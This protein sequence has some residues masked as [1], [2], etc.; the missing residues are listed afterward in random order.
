MPKTKTQKARA[1]RTESAER[2]G[3]APFDLEKFECELFNCGGVE[4]A[5]MWLVTRVDRKQ[6]LRAKRIVE[7]M[8]ISEQREIRRAIFNL[9][10]MLD[11]AADEWEGLYC[12]ASNAA[13]AARRRAAKKTERPAPPPA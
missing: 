1:K 9:E 3:P 8:N 7:E 4:V 2:P 10:N 5:L 11:R 13:W 6:R 12:E